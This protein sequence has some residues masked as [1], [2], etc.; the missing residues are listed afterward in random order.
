LAELDYRQILDVFADAVVAADATGR[1]VYANAA[2]ERLLG[3]PA[4]GLLGQPLT[5][6]M[7]PRM[8]AAHQAGFARYLATRV[9]T[10]LGRPTRVPAVRRDGTELDIELTLAA[11]PL[12]GQQGPLFVASMRDLGDRVELE[13]QLRV[14]RFLH[15]AARAVATLSSLLDLERVVATVVDTLV[16]DFDA[17]LARVWLYEAETNTLHLRASAGLAKAAAT[18]SRARIDVATYPY[19]VGEVARSRRPIVKNG[20]MGDPHFEQAWV[21]REGLQAMAAFPLLFGGELKGVLA[22]FFRQPLPEELVEVLATFAV[23]VTTAVHDVQL[24]HREQAARAE[25]EAARRRAAFLAEASAILTASLDYE[26]TLASVARLAV[27]AMADWCFVDLP[28]GDRATRRLAL[29]FADPSKARLARELGEIRFQFDGPHPIARALRTGQPELVAEV[30]DAWYAAVA[31]DAEHRRRVRE[32]GSKSN[33]FVPLVAR[34]R[35]LGVMTFTI[36][37]SGRRYGEADLALAEEVAR[38]AALAIDNARLFRD[39]QE[40]IRQAQAA[41]RTR[42]T[43]LARASHELRTPLTSALGTA[44]L[45]RRARPGQLPESPEALLAV[46]DRSL[47]AMA[48]LVEDLLD[49]SKLA[50]G[51]E[52]LTRERVDLAEAVGHSLEVVGP[53]AREK[54]VA[55]RVD[56][57]AGLAL[58]ADRLKL[59]QVLV[60]LLANAVKFTPP[61][62]EVTVRGEEQGGDVVLRVRD[63]GEGVVPDQ[64][65]RIFEPFYQAGGLGDSR[66]TDRPGRRIRGTG[67]GLAIC[68]QVV[69]LHGG[70]IWAESEGPGR[71]STF[72]VRLPAAPAGSQAA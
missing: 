34:G 29:A 40:A 57:P 23:V 50:S 67:L 64:L 9:P 2:A 59:E 12:P 30:T 37:D 21:E 55:V 63:T 47:T 66:A 4:G 20:L 18:S 11:P 54:G 7:P 49:A 46:V 39:A 19:K 56:V 42:D 36:T 15:A 53:Q 8:H 17:A 32:L 68:R 45:L 51:Q 25:A 65:E 72:V 60:N 41:V 22:C 14:T 26:A 10:L 24:F 13:R 3:W 1:I 35:T 61:G 71:G 44:R 69:T 27:P 70:R 16:A 38:R 5:S 58:S 52:A 33:M 28:E 31:Q 43:F 6:L 48:A 62:G